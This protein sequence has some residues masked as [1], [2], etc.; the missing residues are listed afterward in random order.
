MFPNEP[1]TV[2]VGSVG[3]NGV[4]KLMNFE[5]IDGKTIEGVNWVDSTKVTVYSRDNV[6][7]IG[8]SASTAKLLGTYNEILSKV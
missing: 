7:L 5:S 1:G 4:K 8:D 3:E 6:Y 2:T